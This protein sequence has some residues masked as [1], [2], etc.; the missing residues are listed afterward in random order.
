ML[1]SVQRGK[2]TFS[3]KPDNLSFCTSSWKLSPIAY[4]CSCVFHR[5]VCVCQQQRNDSS[6]RSANGGGGGTSH[7]LLLS[8]QRHYLK[9]GGK[10][11]RRHLAH[12]LSFPPS[13]WRQNPVLGLSVEHTVQ[14]RLNVCVSRTIAEH[15]KTTPSGRVCAGGPG[16]PLFPCLHDGVRENQHRREYTNTHLFWMSVCS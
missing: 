10:P 9:E 7:G 3:M 12:L 5:T 13:T 11:C 1:C 2:H 6:K 4:S 14:A 8:L 16:F 15:E